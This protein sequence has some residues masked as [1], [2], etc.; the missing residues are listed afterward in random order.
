MAKQKIRVFF[1][2][3]FFAPSPRQPLP[4]HQSPL[5]LTSFSHEKKMFISF[6]AKFQ[7]AFLSSTLL[8]FL[9]TINWKEVYSERAAACG[10][11]MRRRPSA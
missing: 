3:H 1:Y 7:T 4:M 8:F 10:R 5:S 2:I 6:G 11:H 9:T